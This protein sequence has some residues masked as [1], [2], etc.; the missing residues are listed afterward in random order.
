[1]EAE[2]HKQI[3]V[4]LPKI[5]EEIDHGVYSYK[6]KEKN[7][8]FCEDSEN[9]KMFRHIPNVLKTNMKISLGILTILVLMR[10]LIK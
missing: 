6:Q 8:L 7:N 2:W 3:T 1:M 10:G 5:K 4:A 9:V